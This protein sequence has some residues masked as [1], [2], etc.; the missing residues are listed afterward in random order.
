MLCNGNSTSG[1]VSGK[2]FKGYIFDQEK[3]LMISFRDQKERFTPDKNEILYIEEL[4]NKNLKKINSSRVNQGRGC[5]VLHKKLRKFM[6]QYV[7]Y[8]TNDGAKVIWI[9]L[10]WA[11]ESLEKRLSKEIIL[12]QDGCSHYWSIKVNLDTSELFDLKVNGSG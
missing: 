2:G 3:D 7:G 6:R 4:L 8:E 1:F 12:V 11:E 9:N 5:P 10:V